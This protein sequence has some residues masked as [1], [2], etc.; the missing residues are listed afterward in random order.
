LL[1]EQPTLRQPLRVVREIVE[2]RQTFLQVIDG[3]LVGTE[4]ARP[5]ARE[6]V[7][8]DRLLRPD[9]RR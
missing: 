1:H 4:V 2:Q 7:I 5:D 3:L 9:D 6:V 8:A